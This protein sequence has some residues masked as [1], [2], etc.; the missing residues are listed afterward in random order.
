[1]TQNKSIHL[2]LPPCSLCPQTEPQIHAHHPRYSKQCRASTLHISL[3]AL[4]PCPSRPSCQNAADIQ[5]RGRKKEKSKPP[6][7]PTN[8]PFYNLNALIPAS[9]SIKSSALFAFPPQTTIPRSSTANAPPCCHLFPIVVPGPPNSPSSSIP[10][11]IFLP[12]TFPPPLP[13]LVTP[14]SGVS[15]LPTVPFL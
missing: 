15:K 14:P 7:L 11:A 5:Q 12:P 8:S 2:H 10:P 1:M 3:F 9:R 13:F 4:F 6:V